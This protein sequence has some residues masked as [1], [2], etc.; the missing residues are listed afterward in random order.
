[1]IQPPLAD[2][3]EFLLKPSRH[4][5]DRDAAAHKLVLATSAGPLFS[6]IAILINTR[7]LLGCDS[8]IPGSR[9]NSRNDIEF[10]CEVK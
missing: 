1:M 8:W 4:N 7:N 10:R 9:K 3:C 6:P 2:A 5:V